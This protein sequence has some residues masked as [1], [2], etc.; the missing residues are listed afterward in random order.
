MEKK[1]FH[2]FFLRGLHVETIMLDSKNILLNYY[3][4]F[5]SF[6]VASRKLKITRVTRITF[7]LDGAGLDT[8][9]KCKSVNTQ[10]VCIYF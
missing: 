8:T 9:E 2:E 7:L 4:V 5:T 1:V 3:Y 10:K 6:S